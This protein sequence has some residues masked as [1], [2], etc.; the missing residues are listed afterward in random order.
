VGGAS[1]IPGPLP[2][3]FSELLKILFAQNAKIGSKK[4]FFKKLQKNELF[5]IFALIFGQIFVPIFFNLVII[6]YH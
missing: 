2:T 3:N 6:T 1:R 4:V 5:P